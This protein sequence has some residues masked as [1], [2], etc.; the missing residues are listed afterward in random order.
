M[1]LVQGF[2][3]QCEPKTVEAFMVATSITK[4][5]FLGYRAVVSY[6]KTSGHS[7]LNCRGHLQ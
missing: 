6:T 7:D 5:M 1:E 2:T 3:K 4:I